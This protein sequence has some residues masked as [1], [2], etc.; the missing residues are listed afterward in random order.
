MLA[1][2]LADD[3]RAALAV[4]LAPGVE[5]ALL[6]AETPDGTDG[7]RVLAI[8]GRSLRDA[9]IAIRPRT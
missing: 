1:S 7:D 2:S 3:E 8:A 9:G 5:R 6:A 4:L